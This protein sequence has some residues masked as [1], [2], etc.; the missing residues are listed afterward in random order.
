M[1]ENHGTLGILCNFGDFEAKTAAID[2][3][4]RN[5]DKVM[6]ITVKIMTAEIVDQHPMHSYLE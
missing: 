5:V 1:V 3:V 2:L 4:D 6:S